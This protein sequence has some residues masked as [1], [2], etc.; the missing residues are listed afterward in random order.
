[1]MGIKMAEFKDLL[2]KTLTKVELHSDDEIRFYTDDGKEYR[3]H[4]HQDCC[5]LV[6][7]NPLTVKI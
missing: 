6:I 4:H 7:F 1:M 3:M 2:G 5:E